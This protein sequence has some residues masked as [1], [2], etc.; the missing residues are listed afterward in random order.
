MSNT[1]RRRKDEEGDEKRMEKVRQL[2]R[3]AIGYLN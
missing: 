2:G 3:E 1:A